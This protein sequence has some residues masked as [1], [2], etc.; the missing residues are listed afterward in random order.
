[1]SP[2]IQSIHEAVVRVH[3]LSPCERWA[4]PVRSK[5]KELHDEPCKK[6]DGPGGSIGG[7]V[8]CS[9]AISLGGDS[10]RE[11]LAGIQPV[12]LRSADLVSEIDFETW[13]RTIE[14]KAPPKNLFNS[15]IRS[16]SNSKSHSPTP[17]LFSNWEKWG[18]LPIFHFDTSKWRIGK[19]DPIFLQFERK[20]S[21]ETVVV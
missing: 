4:C 20:R 19:N 16:F 21:W 8:F 18:R 15:I 6:N 10:V 9:K 3:S 7:G 13:F 17:I 1:M 2:K 11:F 12:Q 5:T 14:I